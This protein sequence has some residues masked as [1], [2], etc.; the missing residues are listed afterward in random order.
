MTIVSTVTT[1]LRCTAGRSFKEYRIHRDQLANGNVTVRTAYGRIGNV[2]VNNTNA[3]DEL[4][5]RADNL[6]AKLLKDK[7]AK[8]YQYH[9]PGNPNVAPAP[10]PPPTPAPAKKRAP[11]VKPFV[12]ADQSALNATITAAVATRKR[13]FTVAL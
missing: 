9:S 4:P 3:I 8:G 10:A 5:F 6:I 12:P 11:R 7:L 2:N 13:G 1:I